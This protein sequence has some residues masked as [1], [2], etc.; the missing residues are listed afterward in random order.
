MTS[1][2][3]TAAP[4]L[5]RIRPMTFS[6]SGLAPQLD[7]FKILH[8]SDVHIGAFV[9]LEHLG[10]LLEDAARHKPDLV[11]VTGDLADDLGRLPDALGMIAGLKAPHGAW[12]SIGNHEYYQGID[13]VKRAHARSDVP[14][15]MEDSALLRV[16][17]AGL[18]LAGADDPVNLRRD[19]DDFLKGTVQASLR[20][21]PEGAFTVLM[22]HRPRGFVEA[23]RQG[24]ELTLSGHTHGGQ[25]G[26]AGRSLFD[27]K[28][29][30]FWGHYRRGQSQ[31]YTS[32][33]VGHWLPVRLGC[34]TEAPLITLRAA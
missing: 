30:F 20:R 17:G 16:R 6:W 26:R 24:V 10:G 2:D 31:L 34:P 8:L 28:D 13:R 3:T 18:F 14:L 27:H 23:A 25:V 7:G 21:R 32:S 29:N 33:G 5:A 12:A 15:L 4:K 1:A 19:S 9:G 11:L 22:S